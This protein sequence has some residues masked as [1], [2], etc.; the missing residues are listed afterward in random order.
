MARLSQS[1]CN[2]LEILSAFSCRNNF[3]VFHFSKFQ[4]GRNISHCR[5]T[6]FSGH[7]CYSVNLFISFDYTLIC[8]IF[9]IFLLFY[10][11]FSV[12]DNSFILV[13]I[14]QL[15][16]LSLEFN[17]D[18]LQLLFCVILFRILPS[19]QNYFTVLYFIDVLF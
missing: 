8:F 16:Q 2:A 7:S 9:I 3:P 13:L 11:C 4:N 12:L 10:S 19:L 5:S 15:L 17:F 6:Q 1:W 18:L 14:L